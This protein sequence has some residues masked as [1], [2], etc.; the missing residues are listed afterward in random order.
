MLEPTGTGPIVMN[1]AP[2]SYWAGNNPVEALKQAPSHVVAPPWIKRRKV[3]L[4]R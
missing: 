1:G 2:M 4:R 3:L